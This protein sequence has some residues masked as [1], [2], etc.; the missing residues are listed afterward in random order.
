MVQGTNTV[1]EPHFHTPGWALGLLN[2]PVGTALMI[3]FLTR[4]AGVSASLGNLTWM[5][6][7]LGA[8]KSLFLKSLGHLMINP[9][10]LRTELCKRHDGGCP[11]S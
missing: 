6:V 1:I 11:E 4:I 9:L 8:T 2:S 5:L 10:S 3:G 7:Y